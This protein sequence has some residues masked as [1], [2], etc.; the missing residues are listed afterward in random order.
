MPV[1]LLSS[2]RLWCSI[3]CSEH[4]S[5]EFLT[6]E[7]AL[8]CNVRDLSTFPGYGRN[9]CMICIAGSFSN[10]GSACRSDC[11]VLVIVYEII[12][13]VMSM[14]GKERVISVFPSL[15]SLQREASSQYS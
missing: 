12:I 4:G 10:E 9:H 8:K 14:P 6:I 1:N 2:P 5:I 7:Q 15:L 13:A 11:Y 3:V